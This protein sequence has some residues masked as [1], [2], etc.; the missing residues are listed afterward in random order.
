MIVLS[1]KPLSLGEVKEYIKNDD[2]KKALIEYLKNFTLVEKEK[3]VKLAAELSALKNH[4]IKEENIVKII[5]LKPSD[6][7]DVNKIFVDASLTEEEANVV[8]EIVKKY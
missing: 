2:E 3:A 8:L 6:L 5:D 4:K 1:K 7:D